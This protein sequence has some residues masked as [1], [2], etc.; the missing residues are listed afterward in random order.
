MGSASQLLLSNPSIRYVQQPA[1]DFSNKICQQQTWAS[2]LWYQD[3]NGRTQM[4]DEDRTLEELESYDS[5]DPETAPTP[6]V[7]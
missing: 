5:G 7:A 4:A 2:E 3:V 6:M 1:T